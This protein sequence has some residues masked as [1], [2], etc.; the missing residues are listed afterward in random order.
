MW[1]NAIPSQTLTF[2]TISEMNAHKASVARSLFFGSELH[3]LNSA[4]TVENTTWSGSAHS[5]LD[6]SQFEVAEVKMGR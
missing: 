3:I 5:Y 6:G 1:V 2:L 4:E